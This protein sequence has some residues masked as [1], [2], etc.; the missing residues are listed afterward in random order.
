M[1]SGKQAGTGAIEIAYSLTIKDSVSNTGIP[2]IAD[3][4]WGAVV[5][6]IIRR[7]LTSCHTG[8]TNAVANTSICTAERTT[9]LEIYI[10]SL[11]VGIVDDAYVYAV[12][13]TVAPT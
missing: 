8:P 5:W 7:L 3:A 1:E 9:T 4:K 13:L 11:P 10:Q 12:T 2:L 6:Q